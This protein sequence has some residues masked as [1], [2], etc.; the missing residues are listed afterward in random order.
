MYTS[1]NQ[2]SSETRPAR[3][4]AVGNRINLQAVSTEYS[5]VAELDRI[6]GLARP[7]LAK[8]RP[9]LVVLGEDL[10]LPLALAGKRGYL[11]RLMHTSNV[12]I[13]MLA[14]G[15]RRRMIYYR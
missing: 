10:G 11:S 14:L 1:E 15:Y 3:F 2:Y 5:F 4:I 9:N 6:V 8:D 7:H 12:A 13:S